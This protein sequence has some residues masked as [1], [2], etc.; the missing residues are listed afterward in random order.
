MAHAIKTYMHDKELEK[1]GNELSFT[2]E[3]KQHLKGISERCRIGPE[4]VAATIF[5]QNATPNIL[6]RFRSE[7]LNNPS[8]EE[9]SRY[10]NMYAILMDISVKNGDE[11]EIKPE[12]MSLVQKIRLPAHRSL[13][14]KYSPE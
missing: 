5:F 13:F 14:S 9:R 8:S 2:R 10:A 11:R 6:N 3:E 12:L 1:I 7:G 4:R